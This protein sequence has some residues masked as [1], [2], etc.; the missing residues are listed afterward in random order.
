MLQNPVWIYWYFIFLLTFY[1]VTFSILILNTSVPSLMSVLGRRKKTKQNNTK[2]RANPHNKKV[3]I[4]PEVVFCLCLLLCPANVRQWIK[5]SPGC[6]EVIPDKEVPFREN[7]WM[8]TE[9]NK[10]QPHGVLTV[11][12]TEFADGVSSYLAS[13]CKELFIRFKEHFE[14]KM[15]WL[16]FLQ[17]SWLRSCFRC[18]V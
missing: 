8:D 11:K 5:T 4:V 2:N 14:Y 12:P 3:K 6:A 13:G 1:P 7:E 17:K 16:C 10:Y 15:T 9:F 18:D